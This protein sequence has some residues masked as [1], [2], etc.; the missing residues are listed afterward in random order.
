MSTQIAKIDDDEPSNTYLCTQCNQ[1]TIAPFVMRCYHFICQTCLK[2][3]IQNFNCEFDNEIRC[4]VCGLFTCIGHLK[5]VIIGN[6]SLSLAHEEDLALKSEKN[7]QEPKIA[8]ENEKTEIKENQNDNALNK[9]IESP[10]KFSRVSKDRRKD[11]SSV[12]PKPTMRKSK[13]NYTG[14]SIEKLYMPDKFEPPDKNGTTKSP[15]KQNIIP[16]QKKPAKRD[17]KNKKDMDELNVEPMR[18]DMSRCQKHGQDMIYFTDDFKFYCSECIVD[19]AMNIDRRKLKKVCNGRD[20]IR[21]NY[22]KCMKRV[23][24]LKDL[25]QTNIRTLKGNIHEFEKIDKDTDSI[26]DKRF[27]QLYAI[28]EA[29]KLKIKDNIKEELELGQKNLENGLK[30]HL[31]GMSILESFKI[32]MN[33]VEDFGEYIHTIMLHNNLEKISI[34]Q[35]IPLNDSLKNAYIQLDIGVDDLKTQLQQHFN[36]KYSLKIEGANLQD[37]MVKEKFQKKLKQQRLEKAKEKPEIE[38]EYINASDKTIGIQKQDKKNKYNDGQKSTIHRSV[39]SSKGI[40]S[41]AVSLKTHQNTQVHENIFDE[42]NKKYQEVSLADEKKSFKQVVNSK[43][44]YDVFDQ[45]SLA[46]LQKKDGRSPK[47]PTNTINN[48]SKGTPSLSQERDSKHQPIAQANAN[49]QDSGKILMKPRTSAMNSTKSVTINAPSSK[50]QIKPERDVQSHEKAHTHGT[51]MS[52]ISNSHRRI[53][54]DIEEGSAL[55]IYT[56]KSSILNSVT[57]NSIIESLIKCIPIKPID[58]RILMSQRKTKDFSGATFHRV[59]DN[60][61]PYQILC[62]VKNNVFGCYI[63]VNFKDVFEAHETSTHT[64]IFSQIKNGDMDFVD[65]PLRKNCEKFAVCNELFGFCLGK[66]TYGIRDLS[67]NFN[68]LSKCCSQLGEVYE[69]GIE[70]DPYYLCGKFKNWSVDDIEVIQLVTKDTYN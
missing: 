50:Q 64:F 5:K 8:I 18:Q 6:K 12:S 67:F 51:A 25:V 22:S 30:T 60:K 28:F 27:E 55:D 44:F 62:K 10:A 32:N 70:K 58:T 31:K 34:F 46:L 65:F 16:D 17:T 14:K 20:Q 33:A 57:D 38:Q 63:D 2:E 3:Y 43:F 4:R 45:A 24:Y 56:K 66:S 11:I 26:L 47:R 68:D 19:K 23:N 48:S 69:N 39:L 40:S 37:N 1:L 29:Q 49:I 54:G 52:S 42:D 41:K 9:T 59:C 15:K 21:N 61:A 7:K 13:Q 53:V 36:T 35:E